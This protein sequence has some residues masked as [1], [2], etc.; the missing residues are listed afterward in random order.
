VTNPAIDPLR[1][2][3]VMSLEVNIGKRR[4]ILEVGPENASQVFLS[5]PVLNEGE[6]DSLMKDPNLQAQI[7]ST[8]F[9][10]RKG[11][12]GSLEK[13]LQRLCEAADEAVRDGC[14]LLV[15]SD[16]SEELVGKEREASDRGSFR[17]WQWWRSKL[18]TMALWVEEASDVSVGGRGIFGPIP[19]WRRELCTKAIAAKGVA[20]VSNCD[21]GSFGLVHRR[22]RE[23]CTNATAMDQ[24]LNEW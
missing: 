12:D 3:L 4:N 21:R 13:A 14:Q 16:R 8:Y 10:I 1:E 2:G 18:Q 24:R 19:R 6:L 22:R 17:R 23:L 5:S 15:L 7:L 11:L 20:H 9:D